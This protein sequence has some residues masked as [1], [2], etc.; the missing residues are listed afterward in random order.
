MAESEDL[1]KTAKSAFADAGIEAMRLK[2]GFA[3]FIIGTVAVS[4]LTAVL[5]WQIQNKRLESEIIA[6]ENEFVAQFITQAIDKD[7][8]M[9]RDFAEYF[10][11]VSP[12]KNARERWKSYRTWVA[13]QLQIASKKELEIAQLREEKMK[14][15]EE[16]AS[17]TA[18]E[19]KKI[20]TEQIEKVQTNLL[21][22]QQQ[23]ASIRSDSNLLKRDFA[24]ASELERQGFER[25]LEGD[26]NSARRAFEAAERAYPSFHQVHEIARLLKREQ[27]QLS[28]PEVQ[29]RVLTHIISEYSWKAPADLLAAIEQRLAN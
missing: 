2:L 20:K 8:E 26:F 13:D 6:K 18:S 23:L 15:N 3:K 28:S 24:A 29:R 27:S 21:I 11:R 5:N 9:R 7:L 12:S 19:E 25:L 10:T 22:K 17:L 1:K 16:I 14:L 4:V